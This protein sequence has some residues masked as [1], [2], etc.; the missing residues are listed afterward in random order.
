MTLTWCYLKPALLYSGN[1]WLQIAGFLS[2][3]HFAP[4]LGHFC[5]EVRLNSPLKLWSKCWKIHTGHDCVS[6]IYKIVDGIVKK[7]TEAW[8][9]FQGVMILVNQPAHLWFEALLYCN[10]IISGAFLPTGHL[11]AQTPVGLFF[12]KVRST[13]HI[14]L[15]AR[16]G[17][18]KSTIANPHIG[19]T[20]TFRPY[21]TRT[22][23]LEKKHELTHHRAGLLGA[24][25]GLKIIFRIN[26]T[27]FCY[28]NT[29]G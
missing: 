4:K 13:L 6:K 28:W 26:I 17:F 9:Y 18:W 3:A 25:M 1:H 14:G 27:E 20:L 5:P 24:I 10:C 21:M 19:V 22:I 8:L 29:S 12:P 23:D 2:W 15:E 16:V 11:R 7:Q